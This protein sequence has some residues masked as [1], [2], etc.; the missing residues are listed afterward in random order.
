MAARTTIWFRLAVG[1]AAV[2]LLAAAGLAAV[3]AV[4]VDRTLSSE[5]QTRVRFDLNSARAVYDE[6]LRRIETALVAASWRR[7]LPSPG[8][9]GRLGDLAEILDRLRDYAGLDILT[10]VGPDGRAVYR[11][12]NPDASGDDLSEHVLIAQ[13]LRDP[14]PA[15]GTLVV[16]GD[17]LELECPGLGDRAFVP[18]VPTAGATSPARA[19]S[20]DGLV[21]ASA[22][23]LVDVGA[24]D[25]RPAVLY[26]ARLLN[27][28]DDLVDAI[29][30]QVFQGQTWEGRDAG[31]ATVFLD[32][33]RVATNVRGADGRRAVGTRMSDEVRRHVLEQGRAW[34]DRAFV[35]HDWYI[36][37]Y[38]P[39]HDPS[40]R[41]IG[42]LFVGLLD[43]PY[44]HARRVALAST[45]GALGVANLAVLALLLWVSR[46]MLRPITQVV[47]MAERVIAGDLTARTGLRPPGEM[48]A[49]CRAIDAMAAAVQQR[50]ERLVAAAQERLGRAERMASVGRLAAGVAHEV[51]NPLTGVLTFAHLMKGKPNLDADDAQ[52]V[53]VIVRETTRV[54]EIV[55]GLLDFARELPLQMRVID[56]D[57]P[58]RH[59]LELVR[60]QKEF[61]DLTIVTRFASEPLRIWGDRNR[62]QQVFLNLLLNAAQA[63]DGAGTL[64]VATAAREGRL[65]A[66]SVADTGPGIPA[67]LRRRVFEPFFT[68][69]AVGSGAGLGLSISD[70]IVRQHKGSIE[71]QTSAGGGTTFT[72]VLPLAPAGAEPDRPPTEES[73]APA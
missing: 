33:V 2:V 5:V 39:L 68:T 71:L 43:A 16:P 57:E 25:A 23:P 49:L 56:A 20:T 54:R 26:G 66:I 69:K 9:P 36:S 72:V 1:T 51:N 63:M 55:K 14:R 13:V 52:A 8:A 15:S 60:R 12:G 30:G 19:E 70:G 40:G 24:P 35:V 3:A 50:E 48:G 61:R 7:T 47:A 28:R 64:T 18:V 11:T 62:L 41:V 10:L 22:V 4:G 37:A 67:E 44:T 31:T 17:S 21:L 45:L 34:A 27:G 29:A 73:S 32:D 65:A 58:L 42:A 6:Q 59:V 38:A 53:E 46:T